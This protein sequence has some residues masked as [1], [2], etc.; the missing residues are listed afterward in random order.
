MTDF[1]VVTG[2]V[3]EHLPFEHDSIET[4]VVSSLLGF[5]VDIRDL[6]DGVSMVEALRYIE[7][8]V[9]VEVS[10]LVVVGIIAE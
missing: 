10:R 3:I 1:L 5:E 2:V 8:T 9:T 4:V 6:A 7:V